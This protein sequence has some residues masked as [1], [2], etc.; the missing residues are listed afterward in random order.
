MAILS[1]LIILNV[2]LF[3]YR[4]GEME[5]GKKMD[6]VTYRKRDAVYAVIM[7]I[8][9]NKVAIMMNNSKGFLPGGGMNPNETHVECLERESLEETGFTLQVHHYLGNAKQYFQTRQK[10]YLL[11]DG[12]FYTGQFGLYAS[13]PAED[14]HM[15]V[16]MNFEEAKK[17]LFHESHAWAVSEAAKENTACKS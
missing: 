11:N 13:S 6:G 9:M 14:D 7:D 5:F 4:S 3:V 2:F 17:I 16:W 10:E 8:R 12:H 15:L 1:I